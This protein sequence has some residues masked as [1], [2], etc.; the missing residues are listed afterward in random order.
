MMKFRNQRRRSGRN[1]NFVPMINI[2]FLLLIFF[3][4]SAQIMPKEPFE[5][6]I[7]KSISKIQLLERDTLFI[8]SDKTV[9]Y[10]DAFNESAWI[11][12]GK[13]STKTSLSLRADISLPASALTDLIARL[14][15]IGI[16]QVHLITGS[17]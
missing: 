5:L 17:N 1:E 8:S 16:T 15:I 6:V 14:K 4:I 13:R 3:M 11:A 2:I 7:P 12:L 10:N 9:Y